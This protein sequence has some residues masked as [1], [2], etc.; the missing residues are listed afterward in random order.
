[1]QVRT[2]TEHDFAGIDALLA[3]SYTQLMASAYG[4]A[5]LSVALPAMTKAQPKLIASQRFY[6]VQNGA[7]IVGCGGWSLETPGSGERIDG[8]AHIR[9]FA[10]DPNTLGR[11]IGRVL[12]ERCASDARAAGLVKLQ[13]LSSLNAEP[14]YARMGLQSLRRIEIPMGSVGAFPVVL[15]E[16]PL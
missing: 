12:F 6:V 15:M 9:H 10:S 4:A 3:A 16:G 2:A 8:L 5:V 11:G 14:F 13:A 7:D 1:M